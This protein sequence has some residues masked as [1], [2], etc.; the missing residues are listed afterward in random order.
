[1]RLLTDDIEQLLKASGLPWSA[2]YGSKHIR[3]MVAG[4]FAAIL[5]KGRRARRF[6]GP[7][8]KNAVAQIRRAI[9]QGRT[10]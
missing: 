7:A 10:P 4:R 2:D 1:M 5:P 9:K 8:H 3:I 6:E